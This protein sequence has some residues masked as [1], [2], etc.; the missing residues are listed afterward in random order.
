[1][2]HVDRFSIEDRVDPRS[3]TMKP[4][5]LVTGATETVREK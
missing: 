2:I 1:M 5:T 4:T 3:K